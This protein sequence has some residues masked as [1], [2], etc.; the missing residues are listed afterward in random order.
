MAIPLS[1]LERRPDGD[2]KYMDAISLKY[3]GK[4]FPLVAPRGGWHSCSNL[5]R[6]DTPSYLL[7]TRRPSSGFLRAVPC[8]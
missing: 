6:R 8:D 5:R 2:F 3:T 4:P 7:N 1:G